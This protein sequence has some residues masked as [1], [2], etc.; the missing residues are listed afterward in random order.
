MDIADVIQAKNINHLASCYIFISTTLRFKISHIDPSLFIPRFCSKLPLQGKAE[1]I[2]ICALRIIQSMKRDWMAYGRRPTGLCGAAIYIAAKMHGVIIPIQKIAQSV[3]VCED[4]IRKRLNE[5]KNTAASNLTSE[6]FKAI[7][8][9]KDLPANL[10][11][12]SFKP[13][14]ITY[15]QELKALAESI[16]DEA[17]ENTNE[18]N[19]SISKQDV[20]MDLA[21][22]K[23]QVGNSEEMEKID[24]IVSDL[25]SESCSLY[26]LNEE[27]RKLKATIWESLNKEWIKKQEDKAA[28]PVEVKKTKM[29]KK[30][31]KIVPQ[32]AYTAMIGSSKHNSHLNRQGIFMISGK[33]V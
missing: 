14:A 16:E 5:F 23:K 2:T 26:I 11:P 22:L 15:P 27:E 8:I 6:Q 31:E 3:R 4:T 28:R 21:P 18:M 9:E 20:V 10:Y 17:A 24:E 12:P 32:D 25:D 13:L 19:I 1:E 30:K 7:D 29:K 33:E